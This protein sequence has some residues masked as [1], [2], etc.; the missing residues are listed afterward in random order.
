MAAYDAADLLARLRRDVREPT[1]ADF[2]ATADLYA[3]L[4]QGQ[5]DVFQRLAMAVPDAVIGAPT[6]MTTADSGQTYTFGTD[7][8]APTNYTAIYPVGHIS[9]YGKLSDIPDNA[10]VE[11]VDYAMEGDRIRR[12]PADQPYTGAAP[13]Y[14]GIALPLVLDGSTP[15]TLEPVAARELI[16]DA[17]AIRYAEAVPKDPTAYLARLER[18]WDTWVGALQTQYARRGAVAATNPSSGGP[19]R[20]YMGAGRSGYRW[21]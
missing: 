1:T 16:V 9:I 21:R 12:L 5:I 18:H 14:Q 3:W 13:Y 20:R 17:A 8:A 11:G 15:P 19:R 2:P 7:S 4:G 6:Q 10:W